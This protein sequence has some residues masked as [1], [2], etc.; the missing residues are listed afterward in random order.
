MNVDL[1]KKVDSAIRLIRSAAKQAKDKFGEKLEVSYSGGKDSDIILELAKMAGV[2]FE[3]IY[4]CT[5]I[6]PPFTIKHALEN[7]VTIIRPKMNFPQLLAYGGYPNWRYRFCCNTLKEYKVLNVAILGVRACESNARKERYKEPTQCRIYSKSC[8]VQQYFPILTWTDKECLDFIVER[9]LR[10]HP[11]Y[12]NQDGTIDMTKRLGCMC[13]PLTGEKVRRDYFMKYPNMLKVYL[14]GG[15]TFLQQHP[16]SVKHKYGDAYRWLVRDLFYRSDEEFNKEI[17]GG[18]FGG[19][20]CKTL[21]EE[22]FNIK[23]Q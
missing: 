7:N 13:C 3:A 22:Y 15:K 23:L 19:Q 11:L 16:N 4:K 6:D 10:L 18:L 5:T 8:E 2:D 21:L 17:D 9:K 12:F 1:K 14:R 20:N